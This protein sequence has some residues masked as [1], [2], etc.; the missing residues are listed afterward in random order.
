MG[1]S[2]KG[3]ALITVLLIIIIVEILSIFAIDELGYDVI[4]AGRNKTTE[5]AYSASNSG[6]NAILPFLISGTPQ[7]QCFSGSWCAPGGLSVP[8]IGN[9]TTDSYY[10]TT[11]ANTLSGPFPYQNLDTSNLLSPSLSQTML[12]GFQNITQAGFEYLISCGEYVPPSPL[13]AEYNYIGSVY[14]VSRFGSD[15]KIVETGINFMYGEYLTEPSNCNFVTIDV[16]PPS[17]N[18]LIVLSWFQVSR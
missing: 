7:M 15:T 5:Y 4:N 14:F 18:K 2:N 3:I 13:P 17:P 16:F 11:S 9:V 8:A 6:L 10:Y 12:N 1:N